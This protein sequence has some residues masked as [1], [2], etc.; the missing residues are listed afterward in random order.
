MLFSQM[1]QRLLE[2][3]GQEQIA[4]AFRKIARTP[5]TFLAH[6][7]IWYAEQRDCQDAVV[8]QFFKGYFEEGLDI[9]SSSVLVELADR[10]GL[11]CGLFS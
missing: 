1:E 5:N 10:A 4:F 9:G 8:E 7:V 11:K 6:R 2:A 3:G